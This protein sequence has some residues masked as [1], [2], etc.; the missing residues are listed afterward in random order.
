MSSMIA[1]ILFVDAI[2]AYGI[3]L[4]VRWADLITSR[5][6]LSRAFRRGLDVLTSDEVQPISHAKQYHM[7]FLARY[8]TNKTQELIAFC[9]W[10]SFVWAA[11]TARPFHLYS[12]ALN[13]T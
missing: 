3:V 1:F 13:K 11:I 7:H 9:V 2:Y 8:I 5:H 6:N 4:R 10:K 12:Y